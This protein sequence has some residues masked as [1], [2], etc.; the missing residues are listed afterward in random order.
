METND[1][2]HISTLIF[3]YVITAIILEIVLLLFGN[4]SF[5]NILW[6]SLAITLISYIIGDNILLPTTNN[7]VAT[8]SDV[9][10]ALVILYLVNYLW[11]KNEIPFFAALIASVSLGV[12]EWFFHKLI[13]SDIYD[14]DLEDIE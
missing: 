10:L 4:L 3:K 14:E 5:T 12:G 8:I 13:D 1:L 11:M 9:I 6:I 2:R 7:T